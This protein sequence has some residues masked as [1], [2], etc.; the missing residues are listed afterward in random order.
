[1][2]TNFFFPAAGTFPLLQRRGYCTIT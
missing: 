1:L 2:A